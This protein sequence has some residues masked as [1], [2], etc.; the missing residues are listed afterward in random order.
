MKRAVVTILVVSLAGLAGCVA[1]PAQPADPRPVSRPT[2]APLPTVAP[3]A[4]AEGAVAPGVWT[5]GSDARG[6]RALFGQAGSDALLVL[7]CDRAARRVYLSVPGNDAGTLTLRA[8]NLVKGVAA[9]PTGAT[10][11]YV[12][13]E[14]APTDPV[15]D[16]LA[17]SRGRFSVAIDTRQT[18]VPAWPEF[19]RVVEDCRA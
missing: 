4:V 2:V 17:F 9:R 10:P 14:L 11:A 8:S 19:T 1:P 6:S 13:A 18:T 12:A 7:R 5:Y 16:A 15:L 3:V